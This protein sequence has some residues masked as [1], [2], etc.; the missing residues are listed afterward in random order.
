MTVITPRETI[1]ERPNIS[2]DVI[3][4]P[5]QIL[6]ANLTSDTL[7]E[8]H[9]VGVTKSRFNDS[10]LYWGA[11]S[12]TRSVR[13]QH[14]CERIQH[15]ESLKKR[16][17]TGWNLSSGMVAGLACAS[18]ALLLAMLALIFWR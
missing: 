5:R 8:V 6:L 16:R 4:L 18:F 11:P 15:M 13:L 14:D 2:P 3:F 1:T 7:Y 17:H 9:V 10:L 12:E